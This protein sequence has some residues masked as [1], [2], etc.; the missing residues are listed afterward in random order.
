VVTGYAGRCNFQVG[1]VE[2]LAD[3]P[4]NSFQAGILSN[5]L[6]NLLPLDARRVVAHFV[7]LPVPGGKLL[8]KLNDWVDPPSMAKR[9]AER[10]D[11]DFYLEKEGIY[12][13][14][15]KDQLAES[16]WVPFFSIERAVRVHFPEFARWNRLYRLLRK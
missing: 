4:W 3:L 5:V 15:L 6:N 8:I 9:E 11:E 1:L 7:R 10:L 2:A 16:L 12:L 13:W 14:N